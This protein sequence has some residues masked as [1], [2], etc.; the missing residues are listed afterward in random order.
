MAP[1]FSNGTFPARQAIIAE[2]PAVY[3]MQTDGI[4]YD[5]VREE[6]RFCVFLGVV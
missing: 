5:Q 2:S 4:Q 3:A 1:L 6:L